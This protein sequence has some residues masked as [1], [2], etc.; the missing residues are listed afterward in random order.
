MDSAMKK[1]N[2]KVEV[3]QHWTQAPFSVYA[4]G[5]QILRSLK[6]PKP[7]NQSKVLKTTEKVEK[8]FIEVLELGIS[9][10]EDQMAG[11]EGHS[12]ESQRAL[13]FMKNPLNIQSVLEEWVI[14]RRYRIR[15]NSRGHPF[16]LTSTQALRDEATKLFKDC[17]NHQSTEGFRNVAI[18]MQ[19]K[20][21]A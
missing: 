13:K 21:E 11:N 20:L 18:L 15:R 14:G 19:L 6:N 5:L 7:N 17:L 10:L 16:S 12:E 3:D 8:L 2:W 1:H 9:D 4:E